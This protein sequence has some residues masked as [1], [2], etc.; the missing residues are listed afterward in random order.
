MLR[1]GGRPPCRAGEKAEV[2]SMWVTEE[3]YVGPLVKQKML[4]QVTHGL[5]EGGKYAPSSEQTF[6]GIT[7]EQY[8][9]D[10]SMNLVH[11]RPPTPGH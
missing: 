3:S 11:S 10:F 1:V 4:L 8:C 6:Y 7:I 5:R 9:V 2:P